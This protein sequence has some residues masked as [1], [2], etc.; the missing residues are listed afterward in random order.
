MLFATPAAAEP[1]L[2]CTD[3]YKG[4]L[5]DLSQSHK[6]APIGVGVAKSGKLVTLLRSDEGTWSL[7]IALEPDKICIIGAGEGWTVIPPVLNDPRT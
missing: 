5:S 6:E 1:G 3:S 4:A 2:I 7:L